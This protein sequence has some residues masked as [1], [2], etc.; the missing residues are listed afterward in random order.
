MD[1]GELPDGDIPGTGGLRSGSNPPDN[2]ATDYYATDNH[3][4][5]NH[6]ADYRTPAERGSGAGI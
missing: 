2:H 1:G 4:T 5:D 3:A 6:A